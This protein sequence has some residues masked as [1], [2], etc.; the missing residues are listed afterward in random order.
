MVEAGHWVKCRNKL[1]ELHCYI[2]LSRIAGMIRVGEGTNVIYDAYGDEGHFR[3]V[4]TPEEILAMKPLRT[5]F[6]S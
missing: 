1:N 3:V 5:G 4:E 2:N 6:G